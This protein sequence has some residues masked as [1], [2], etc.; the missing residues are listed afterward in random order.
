MG[1]LEIWDAAGAATRQATRSTCGRMPGARW[2][3]VCRGRSIGVGHGVPIGT[4][5]DE[6]ADVTLRLPRDE[7]R[8]CSKPRAQFMRYPGLANGSEDRL[9]RVVTVDVSGKPRRTEGRGLRRCP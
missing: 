7:G 6:R 1:I 9:P 2:A 3:R 5:F 8:T 4:R